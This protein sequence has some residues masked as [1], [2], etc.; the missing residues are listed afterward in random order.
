MVFYINIKN[1]KNI[2]RTNFVNANI[3][4]NLR[5]VWR[6]LEFYT[7]FNKN[8]VFFVALYIKIHTHVKKGTPKNFFLAFID[9][10]EKEII[11]KKI[12]EVGQ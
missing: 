1:Y 3:V 9:K 10:L 6:K 8:D 12:V 5:S 11:I 4:L 2:T 7:R